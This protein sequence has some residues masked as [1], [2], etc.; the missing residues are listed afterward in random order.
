MCKHSKGSETQFWVRGTQIHLIVHTSALH[1]FSRPQDVPLGPPSPGNSQEHTQGYVINCIHGRCEPCSQI[2]TWRNRIITVLSS[3]L[4]TAIHAHVPP[5]HLPHSATAGVSMTCFYWCT[6][7]RAT[8]TCPQLPRRSL[9]T[10]S[11]GSSTM[12]ATSIRSLSLLATGL[13]AST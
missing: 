6:V 3:G 4:P 7:P 8:P 2:T 10:H 1:G 11:A 13:Q 12:I 9:R 5:L